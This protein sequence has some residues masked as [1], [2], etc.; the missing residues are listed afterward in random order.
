M[1]ENGGRSR[2]VGCISAWEDGAIAQEGRRAVG[3]GIGANVEVEDSRSGTRGQLVGGT[4]EVQ[5]DERRRF[6]ASEVNGKRP[7][8]LLDYLSS[9]ANG[10]VNGCAALVLGRCLDY[11]ATD[12]GLERNRPVKKE[13]PLC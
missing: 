10:Q 1:G 2:P 9:E 11:V 12:M 13:E 7:A 8:S 5:V 3:R 4:V 6:R